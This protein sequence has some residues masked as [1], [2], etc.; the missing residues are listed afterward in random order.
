MKFDIRK[1]GTDELVY[2]NKTFTL[3]W[4]YQEFLNNFKTYGP[5]DDP[6][7]ESDEYGTE[8][9]REYEALVKEGKMTELIRELGK[10]YPRKKESN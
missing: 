3:E 6:N 7:D 9:D 4:D 8:F 1:I 2:G 5:G 10:F